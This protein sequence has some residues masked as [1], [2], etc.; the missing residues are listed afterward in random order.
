[1]IIWIAI[2][3]YLAAG[4]A[5]SWLYNKR[6]IT[7]TISISSIIHRN[8]DFSNSAGLTEYLFIETSQDSITY[9]G[10][11]YWRRKKP[12]LRLPMLVNNMLGV[13]LWPID[14]MMCEIGHKKELDYLQ[15]IFPAEK[16]GE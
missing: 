15:S 7:N 1:M 10:W 9:A 5:A 16:K 13:L 4:I 2:F 11:W 12:F 8:L 3:L 14:I 6:D